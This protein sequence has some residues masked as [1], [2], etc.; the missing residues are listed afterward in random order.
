MIKKDIFGKTVNY[1]PVKK[2]KHVII[3][4]C[5]QS[6]IDPDTYNERHMLPSLLEQ[7]NAVYKDSET[8]NT[9]LDMLYGA[10]FT[11]SVF[12]RG[13]MLSTQ[14]YIRTINQLYLPHSDD[15]MEKAL[16]FLHNIIY[17]PKMYG[18]MITKKA[19][20]DKLEETRDIISTI[21]QDKASLAYF[22]F[23][24]KISSEI[25]P[26]NFPIESKF[27]SISQESLTKVYRQM[28]EE[29][30]LKVY[31]IGDF[32]QPKTDTILKSYI[33]QNKTQMDH[34]KYRISLPDEAKIGDVIET[35]D[36]SI[37]RVYI[38]YKIHIDLDPREEALMELFNIIVGGHAQSKLFKVIREEMHLVYYIYSMYLTENEMFVIHFE[39]ESDDEDKGITEVKNILSNLKDGDIQAS[40]LDLAKHLLINNYL[41]LMDHLNGQ[42]KVNIISDLTE[43]SPF[44]MDQRVALIESVTKEDLIDF[45][46]RLVEHITYRF[47]QGGG[48]SD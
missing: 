27:D 10:R 29:D 36:V 21:H 44:N 1:I 32:D 15:L 22:N 16:E 13:E 43:K 9:H 25:Y 18:S 6:K 2:F 37:S 23:L 3:G 47:K 48:T 12:Q 39:C 19:V 24:K 8:Y 42:L 45:S 20:L 40:E 33:S 31:V 34:M 28:V 46:K 17:R 14:F 26:N 30:E 4:F 38:G 7:H 5:F 41:T 11:T 35:C